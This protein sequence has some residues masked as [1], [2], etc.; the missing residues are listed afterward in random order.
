MY[1]Q[2]EEEEE[3][4]IS[5]NLSSEEFKE[6][7]DKN[8]K[9]NKSQSKIK[10]N[11][12]YS[13]DKSNDDG[14]KKLVYSEN[15]KILNNI[16]EANDKNEY[17]KISIDNENFNNENEHEIINTKEYVPD[18]DSNKPYV[19]KNKEDE[20]NENENPK[21]S[22]NNNIII[23]KNNDD[24]FKMK[25]L[26]SH[27][28]NLD[29]NKE[30]ENNE[31][32]ALPFAFP[33]NENNNNDKENYYII[34]NQNE[35][36]SN[37][38]EKKEE[39]N[40][41]SQ[42]IYES[43]NIK[44]NKKVNSKINNN[45]IL[46][47]SENNNN[48]LNKKD[49]ENECRNKKII[50]KVLDDRNTYYSESE[51]SNNYQ[52][53][54][55][56]KISLFQKEMNQNKEILK[57]DGNKETIEEQQSYEP[58]SI[59]GYKKNN[60][61]DNKYIKRNELNYLDKK[62]E[63]INNIDKNIMK[64]N[65]NENNIERKEGNNQ[66]N[67]NYFSYDKGLINKN[68]KKEKKYEMNINNGRIINKEINVSNQTYNI[69]E[70]KDNKQILELF[71][72][73]IN[74]NFTNEKI[75]ILDKEIVNTNSQKILNS[76]IN[77]SNNYN[78]SNNNKDN[79]S[80]NI[81]ENINLLNQKSII[82]KNNINIE[83]DNTYKNK[84]N[85]LKN[86]ILENNNNINNNKKESNYF[87]KNIEKIVDINKYINNNYIN[88]KEP[89]SIIAN[90]FK[91]DFI[92]EKQQ[93]IDNNSRHLEEIQN[94]LKLSDSINVNTLESVTLRRIDEEEAKRTVELEKEAKRLNE[95]ESE[96]LKLIEEEKEVRLKIIEEI[97]KQEEKEREEKKKRMK[98]KYVESMKKRKE[99]EE[100][101]RQIKLKQEMELKEINE[102]K[103]KKKIEEE[104]LLLLIRGKLNRQEIKNYRKS[105]FDNEIENNSS[106][107]QYKI[108]LNLIKDNNNNNIKIKSQREIKD[109]QNE[110]LEENY[111]Y[112]NFTNDN[113]IK[114]NH[115]KYK[116]KSSSNRNLTRLLQENDNNIKNIENIIN[117]E[118][119]KIIARNNS[120]QYLLPKES[121]ITINTI[122][123]KSNQM[124]INA[125]KIL[126]KDNNLND[127]IIF[128]PS[129]ITKKNTL[130]LSPATEFKDNNKL[131]TELD[132]LISF[133]PAQN[134]NSK[135]IGESINKKET[136][137][138]SYKE[139]IDNNFSDK[140]TKKNI[141]RFQKKNEN[142]IRN[143]YDRKN[144]KEKLIKDNDLNQIK[145]VNSK[146][147]NETIK[148][149]QDNRI[150]NEPLL[151]RNKSSSAN[152]PYLKYK[153][154]KQ[155][156]N[157][158]NN[159]SYRNNIR[160]F[161]GQKEGKENEENIN[162]YNNFIKE[163]NK[164]LFNSR[165][166]KYI[167]KNEDKVTKQ[168]S[169]MEDYILPNENK[170]E[171]RENHQFNCGTAST[172]DSRNVNNSKFVNNKIQKEK[173][174]KMLK[175]SENNENNEDNKTY[176]CGS[177]INHYE[178]YLNNCEKNNFNDLNDNN[179]L[180]EQN[181][182][183][184]LMYYEE[185]Y[186]DNKK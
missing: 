55:N 15:N 6:L 89:E 165:N 113:N 95:L 62:N 44:I 35:N 152:N 136:K 40:K 109:N 157:N 73:N 183:K 59:N 180:G 76:K 159:F 110:N 10:S 71:Q 32:N 179:I 38:I 125:T 133:S 93:Q 144:L 161:N 171:N 57:E 143:K 172:N 5:P 175:Y 56:E 43:E 24:Y 147:E 88:S 25:S 104:K 116:N 79:K 22:S 84:N 115:N 123:N 122:K 68:L 138:E 101:L 164:E 12:I 169:F 96:K 53:F 52:A 29:I 184:F 70:K 181:N 99:D 135:M 17:L 34:N 60:F 47:K 121:M 176:L 87:Q 128:S 151:Y 91:N 119:N 153:N 162:K 118:N 27:S 131:Q 139:I 112:P 26:S 156:Q 23:N 111:K 98:L 41:S 63:N 134:E 94:S 11:I 173:I 65:G 2:K 77:I 85:F 7:T 103:N 72:S 3:E 170:K 182:S 108:S 67:Y 49:D 13:I 145:E 168:K 64:I 82:N 154:N 185:I 100:K 137:I 177:Q 8:D 120:N 140:K 141:K 69:Q 149:N 158:N 186:G 126:D 155:Y 178:N 30:I 51:I 78:I 92:S 20:E 80:I 19:E 33:Y 14:E 132:Q 4:N 66:D 75:N 37:I 160:F 124:T 31:N 39:N 21:I 167:Y 45:Y 129:I 36:K 9:L 117:N 46:N 150:V 48:L 130:S 166:H 86:N 61:E 106:L 114:E 50:N 18:D 74:Q 81:N 16:E 28:K 42:N 1:Y 58:F 83:I 174:K 54:L 105:F 163:T 107:N 102:L 148:N 127:N 97:K 90:S 142:N 146:M